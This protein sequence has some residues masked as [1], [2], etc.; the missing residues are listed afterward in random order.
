MNICKSELTEQQQQK[1]PMFSLIGSEET[2][3]TEWAI[4]SSA[5]EWGVLKQDNTLQT[6]SL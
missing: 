3:L 4:H 6:V 5:K 1:G 2:W